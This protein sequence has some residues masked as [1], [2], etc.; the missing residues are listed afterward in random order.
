[1]GVMYTLLAGIFISLQGIFNTRAGEKIG[2]WETTT[3]VHGLGFAVSLLIWLFARDGSFSRINEVNKLYLVGG[4]LGVMIIFCVMKS[5]AL[6]G[7]T[8]AVSMLLVTQLVMAMAIDV[9]GLFGSPRISL[10]FTKPLGVIVMILGIL[11]FKL[12]G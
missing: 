1:M 3:L 10:H 7:P 12:K 6:L 9:F 11:L 8:L 5:F 2:M 4:A